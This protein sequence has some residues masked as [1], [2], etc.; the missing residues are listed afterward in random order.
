MKNRETV[1]ILDDT[2]IERPRAKKVELLARVFDHCEGRF[3]KDFAC[4]PGLVRRR[5]PHPT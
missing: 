3:L 4:D 2:A 5:E 1:L